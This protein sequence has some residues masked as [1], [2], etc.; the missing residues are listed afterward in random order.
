M[1]LHRQ[2][3]LLGP[4]VFRSC[5]HLKRWARVETLLAMIRVTGIAV[6]LIMRHEGA[7][8]HFWEEIHL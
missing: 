1:L 4:V 7:L 6:V 5:A 2:P 3:T 8:P